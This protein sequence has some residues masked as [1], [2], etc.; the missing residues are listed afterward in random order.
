MISKIP[1]VCVCVAAIALND[2]PQNRL[3]TPRYE[4]Q[5]ADPAWLRT[6]VQFHGHLGPSIVAGARFGM[7][8]LEAVDAKGYFD[9]EVTCEGPLSKPPQSCFLDGL[10]V[11]AGATMGKRN[12]NYVEAKELVVRVKNATTGATA[13]LRPT[14]KLLELLDLLRTENKIKTENKSK[15]I[16]DH[17]QEMEKIEAIARKIAVMPDRE[18]VIVKLMP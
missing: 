14:P 18:I 6:V 11:G 8:G 16:A 7:A 2:E 17:H 9:I 13:E 4:K 15:G 12:L 1:F 3:P 10:Q 5:E